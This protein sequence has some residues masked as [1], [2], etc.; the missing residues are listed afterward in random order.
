MNYQWPRVRVSSMRTHGMNRKYQIFISSTYGDLKEER[1]GVAKAVLKLGFI[2][3][4]MEAFNA[5]D[6]QSWKIIQRHI[7]QSDYYVLIVAH[8]YGSRVEEGG[9]SFTEKEFD[10]AVERGIPVLGFIIE[11]NAQWAA[12]KVDKDQDAVALKS[13]KEKVRKRWASKGGDRRADD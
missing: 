6:S 1:D 7:E 13:F 5:S 2:P 10:Y 8:R 3:V 9:L 12:S 11:D 4:G